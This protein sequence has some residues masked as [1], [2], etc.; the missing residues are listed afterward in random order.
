MTIAKRQSCRLFIFA[1]PYRCPAVPGG[2]RQQRHNHN[3]K[4]NILIIQ[5]I[6]P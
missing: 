4:Y 1:L 2:G 6:L 3:K 5:Y